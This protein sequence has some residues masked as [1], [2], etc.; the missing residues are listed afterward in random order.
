M[1]R[2]CRVEVSATQAMFFFVFFYSVRSPTQRRPSSTT[3]CTQMLEVSLQQKQAPRTRRVHSTDPR[4]YSRKYKCRF[5]PH[6]GFKRVTRSMGWGG[7]PMCQILTSLVRTCA[8]FA[9]KSAVILELIRCLTLFRNLFSH[10]PTLVFFLLHPNF[11]P[12][13]LSRIRAVAPTLR[14]CLH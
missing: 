10:H 14:C 5:P 7:L 4:C 2:S 3:Y 9:E 12:W 8:R 6:P 13:I 1:P 11:V